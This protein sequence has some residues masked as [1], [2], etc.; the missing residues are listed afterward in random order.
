MVQR[1]GRALRWGAIVGGIAFGLGFFVPLLI[2]VAQE[3]LTG[4]SSGNGPLLGFLV[5]P[6]AFIAGFVGGLFG[7]DS[8]SKGSDDA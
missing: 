2:A 3:A 5:A 8:R 1:L 6:P 7:S 4:E